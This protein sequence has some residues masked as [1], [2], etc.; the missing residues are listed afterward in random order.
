MVEMYEYICAG[1]DL[2]FLSGE[3]VVIWGMGRSALD[4]YVD[5]ST[6]DADVMGF[7]DSYCSGGGVFAGKPVYDYKRLEIFGE[8]YI[9]IS[10][11][12]RTFQ[13]DIMKRAKLLTQAKMI[14]FGKFLYGPGKYDVSR[15]KNLIES[16]RDIINFVR[17]SLHD[18]ESTRIFDNLLEYRMTNDERLLSKSYEIG[19]PQYFPSAEEK[20]ITPEA[21]EIFIDAGAYNGDTT[22]TF[23]KWCD[24]DYRK[25]YCME[26]DEL[27]YEIV[28]ENMRLNKLDRVEAVNKGAYSK[29]WKTRFYSDV[30]TGSSLI[31]DCGTKEIETIS[32]DEMVERGE[33]VTF[34]KMD[35]EG[36]EMEALYGCE[37]TIA[38]Y[39]PKLAISIYH[40]EDD[41]WRIPAYLM[42]KYQ[43]YRYYIRHY[44]DMT[45][46]T[47]LYAT[48]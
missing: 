11:S 25:I 15:M 5:L 3:K 21:D 1:T 13:I 47:I 43:D 20:I 39:M 9:F 24:G 48:I 45:T 12:N 26:P 37:G 27:M 8:I 22:I 10:T 2:S 36:A 4:L 33:K 28:K 41:L 38:R 23:A 42:K 14:C 46:E 6:I 19:H 18:S 32:I 30:A 35:I 17:K 29:K 31:S 34:I 40:K 16:D 44:T 7:T